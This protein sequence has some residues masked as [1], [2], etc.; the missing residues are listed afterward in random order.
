MQIFLTFKHHFHQYWMDFL[1]NYR[2]FLKKCPL[3]K[4]HL[5]GDCNFWENWS[6]EDI[7]YIG[8]KK[9]TKS[10]RDLIQSAFSCIWMLLLGAIYIYTFLAIFRPKK[11]RFGAFFPIFAPFWAFLPIFGH[12][13]PIFWGLRGPNS[14]WNNIMK[15]VR[16]FEL[17]I[18]IHFGIR[19]CSS[20]KNNQIWDKIWEKKAFEPQKGFKMWQ[21]IKF[22]I[23]YFLIV[24]SEFSILLL[25][26]I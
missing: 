10:D 7:Y 6:C 12:F 16:R 21:I 14:K 4:N 18:I 25:I 13:C 2:F 22:R 1:Q 26:F 24:H 9:W 3:L 11:A 19:T 17:D 8:C 20:P 23:T 15:R 5:F